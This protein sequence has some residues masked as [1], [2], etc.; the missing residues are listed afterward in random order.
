MVPSPHELVRRSQRGDARAFTELIARYERSALALAYA[1]TTD[2]DRAADAVQ[3]A[4]IRAWTH[5]GSLKEPQRFGAWLSNIVR[6]VCADQHRRRRETGEQG[7]DQQAARDGHVIDELSRREEGDRVAAALAELEETTRAALVL[8]YYDG[9]S[10][11][12]IAQLLEI[13]PAAVDMR[14]MRGRQELR[15]LLEPKGH[16]PDGHSPEGHSNDG[17]GQRKEEES[18]NHA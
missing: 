6:N 1:A 4:F 15:K 3:E 16:S 9:L 7:L 14:L 8:R 10:S 11:K 2:A 13:S 5:L 17:H 18:L 12:E